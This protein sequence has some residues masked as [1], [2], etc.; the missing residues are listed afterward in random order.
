MWWEQ[1]SLPWKVMP[2]SVKDSANHSGGGGGGGGGGDLTIKHLGDFWLGGHPP[3]QWS[4]YGGS[5]L[6]LFQLLPVWWASGPRTP[7]RYRTVFCKSRWRGWVVVG[8]PALLWCHWPQ[9]LP[10]H[11]CITLL[12]LLWEGEVTFSGTA[13]QSWSF[14]GCGS[15]RDYSIKSSRPSSFHVG[16]AWERS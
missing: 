9:C 6:L 3:P 10:T 12:P 15:C 1:Q 14:R 5:T 13:M 8:S 4:R 16:G 2:S 7:T 11:V